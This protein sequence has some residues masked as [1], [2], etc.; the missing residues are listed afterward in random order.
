MVKKK[1][2]KALK[3]EGVL[4]LANADRS[5]M[6]VIKTR[7]LSFFG[8]IMRHDSLQKDLLEGK[9]GGKRSQWRLSFA[10]ERQYSATDHPDVCWMHNKM[11]RLCY[12]VSHGIPS[13]VFS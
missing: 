13:D 5:L 2:N 10:V 11:T 1:L 4:K 9:V 7:K 6:H 12:V 3:N 8:Y